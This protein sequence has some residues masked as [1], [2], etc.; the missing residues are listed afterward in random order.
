MADE[1][2]AVEGTEEGA[3]EAAPSGKRKIFMIAGAVVLTLAVGGLGWYVFLRSHGD[4]QHADA[5]AKVSTPPVFLDVP[6]VLVNLA[7]NPGERIQYLKVKA[8]L[9][10]KDAPLVEKVKPS[11]PR[12]ADL[13]QTY[14]RELRSNDLNGSIGLFRMKEEL[15]KR[16]N[17]AIAPEHVNAVLFKEVVIQ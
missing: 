17:A 9:E 11:M 2:Q 14:L 10:L 3:A 13:F 16:V 12:V 1:D 15:T 5:Q 8:V 7:S 6:D 4:E